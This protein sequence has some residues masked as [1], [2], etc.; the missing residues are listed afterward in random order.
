LV[1]LGTSFGNKVGDLANKSFFVIRNGMPAT[2]ADLQPGDIVWVMVGQ[3][4]FNL[5]GYA[6][7]D[8]LIVAF[9]PQ[10]LEVKGKLTSVEANADGS[11]KKVMVNDK[12]YEVHG[13]TDYSAGRDLLT[14]GV[15][16][17]DPGP[18]GYSARI[19]ELIMARIPELMAEGKT[20]EEAQALATAQ[21]SPRKLQPMVST[22]GGETFEEIASAN[23]IS[24]D[25]Y[26]L[27]DQDVTLIMNM[28]GKVGIIISDVEKFDTGRIFG[29]IISIVPD[30]TKDSELVDMIKIVNKDDE[31][32][33]YAIDE[34]T[35]YNGEEGLDV[36]SLL[37]RGDLVGITLNGDG[38]IDNIKTNDI[39]RDSV[40]DPDDVDDDLDSI[41]IGGR[42]SSAGKVV[43]FNYKSA[44]QDADIMNWDDIQDTIKSGAALDFDYYVKDNEIKYIGLKDQDL[45]TDCN[46]AVI[47]KNGK[48][49]EDPYA[50]IIK[51]NQEQKYYLNNT[52]SYEE[53][54]KY[55]KGNLLAFKW[56]G[57][58]LRIVPKSTL[59]IQIIGGACKQVTD[60]KV[61][62]NIIELDEVAYLVDEDTVVY[63]STD[64]DNL[65]QLTLSDIARVDSV[66]A[67]YDQ[68]QKVLAA[69]VITDADDARDMGIGAQ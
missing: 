24:G 3:D 36:C 69:I 50:V 43:V 60:V 57:D 29:S 4:D 27:L 66:Y 23:Y 40:N 2:L 33:S 32:V 61:Q 9:A 5:G 8:N 59:L 19:T 58:K 26:N 49:S 67:V 1:G 21:Y 37:S 12:T 34:D 62:D 56:E 64:H 52:A 13:M 55:K 45:S 39:K 22:D 30:T 10:M 17:A 31:E 47:V 6:G 51:G 25:N 42:W 15:S 41:K 68:D 35:T 46:Y 65:Q 28:S 11:L 53:I 20:L 7:V 38:N 48:D 16:L 54:K 14:A 63:D 44:D 18:D